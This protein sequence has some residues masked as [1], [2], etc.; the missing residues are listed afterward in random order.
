MLRG[1]FG[2]GKNLLALFGYRERVDGVMTLR[3]I[4]IPRWRLPLDYPTFPDRL[5]RRRRTPLTREPSL[6]FENPREVADNVRELER[7]VRP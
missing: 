5:A 3:T 4:H 7:W 1:I 6:R 2:R